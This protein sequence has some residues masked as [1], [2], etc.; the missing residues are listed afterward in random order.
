[1]LLIWGAIIGSAVSAYGA[2]RTGK[3]S[4][5]FA[6]EMSNTAHQREVADLRAAGLNPILSATGGAG[7]STP[8]PSIPT[9]GREASAAGIATEQLRL[10]KK[11]TRA[12]VHLAEGQ[13]YD[14]LSQGS[15]ARQT[16]ALR[17]SQIK[18]TDTETRAI[19]AGMP[20]KEVKE[21][22]WMNFDQWLQ[23]V[24]PGSSAAEIKRN[25][26]A[27]WL[28]NLFKKWEDQY[29]KTNKEKGRHK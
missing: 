4:Q 5:R 20:R 24:F 25:K 10:A 12:N 22:I 29:Q 15:L 3:A 11:T 1:M 16:S 18:K 13:S 28:G 7:A 6:R 14:A 2:Y 26:S 8:T 9:I 23:S 19:E 21:R 17:V 27:P